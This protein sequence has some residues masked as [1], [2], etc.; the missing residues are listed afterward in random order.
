MTQNIVIQA[1][2]SLVLDWVGEILYFPIWWYTLGLKRIFL[3][4][5][6]SIKNANRNL[7]LG[8][9]FKHMFSPMFGQYDKQ[10]R[11]ISFFMRFILIIFRLIAFVFMLIF[12]II[13]LIFWICLPILV[14]WGLITNFTEIWKQ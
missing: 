10:G 14:T 6:N 13:V 5:W 9:M 7:A 11:A 8:L 4:V 12:Y 2:K 1:I 3:F